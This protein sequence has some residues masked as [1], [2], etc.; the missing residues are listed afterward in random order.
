MQTFEE[1]TLALGQIEGDPTMYDRL[2]E[3]DVP[4]L[5]RLLQDG[6]PWQA[7]RA[8]L[9]LQRVGGAVSDRL[10]TDAATDAR[11]P[12]RVA[13]ALCAGDLPPHVSDAALEQ[14][15]QDSE[16]SVRKVALQS[17]TSSSGP[18]VRELLST[19]V[20]NEPHDQL[21]DLARERLAA[22]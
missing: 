11:D 18:R 7:A 14:L 21:R 8:V 1:V 19:M 20:T 17:V 15:V 5:Q 22:M 6:A 16:P 3:S 10:I 12:V 13:V 2:D 9:G 4:H